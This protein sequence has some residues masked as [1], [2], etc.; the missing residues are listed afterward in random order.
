MTDLVDPAELAQRYVEETGRH[1]F[2]TGR[3]GT[4]K[5]T[6]L[7]KIYDSTGKRV[8]I[9]APTGVAAINAGGVTLHSLLQLPFGV[10]T[11]AAIAEKVPRIRFHAQKTA[12]L[13]SLDLLIIDEVSMVRADVLDGVDA[14]LR[15]VRQ[16]D[17]PF[18]GVQL[19]LIGDLYQLPPVVVRNEEQVLADHYPSPYF[20]DSRALKQANPRVITLTRVY[21]QS[22]GEFLDLLAAVR[23]NRLTDDDLH[24]LNQR[25]RPEPATPAASDDRITLSSHNRDADRINATRLAALPGEEFTFE[26][27]TTGKFP[28]SMY[29][30]EPTLS[31]RVGAR[32]M[33]NRNDPDK[34]YY[35][36]KIGRITAIDG[37]DIR[38]A[39]AEDEWP[40]TVTPATWENKQF[41][42]GDDDEVHERTVGT[43]VQ[44]PLRLAWAITIH[45]SQGL[46]FDRVIIDAGRAFAHGQVY[47]AL[48]RCRTLEGIELRTRIT[49]AAVR[50]DGTVNNFSH[51]AAANPPGPLQ[52]REDARAYAYRCLDQLLDPRQP[53]RR[54]EQLRR[55][56]ATH[57]RALPPVL[58]SATERLR[59]DLGKR[60]AEPARGFGAVVRR[61]AETLNL[62]SDH[63]ELAPRLPK[64][65]AY[66]TTLLTDDLLPR[67]RALAVDTDNAA[68]GARTAELIDEL[69]R[70]LFLR[71]EWFSALTAD[72]APP[73]FLRARS[74]AQR[75]WEELLRRRAATPAEAGPRREVTPQN[76]SNPV[77]YERLRRWRTREAASR[78][79]PQHQVL[80]LTVLHKIADRAPTTKAA[81]RAIPGVGKITVERYGK[82]LLALV[83]NAPRVVPAAGAGRRSTGPHKPE[84]QTLELFRT[85]K[86]PVDIAAARGVRSEA[87]MA[88]L[89]QLAEAGKLNPW[90]LVDDRAGLTT[91]VDHLRHHPGEKPS[92][93]HRHFGERYS[94]T[95]I[96]VARAVLRTGAKAE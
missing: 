69:H 45:K 38:V 85:G 23:D 82:D 27:T 32:V 88:Q 70:E 58:R 50:T 33:F 10:L 56:V 36:G 18:G 96:R 87:V 84:T 21:R 47:V 94:F 74:R 91:V 1:L 9:T 53:D 22:D 77:L 28:E 95:L 79:L 92:Q 71:R 59:M 49:P 76:V 26:A 61:A 81:L 57:E 8:V 16:T 44:H 24:R 40:I 29:P 68:V 35:N 17:Q 2:L 75:H 90:K 43:Y 13:R 80:Q 14:V 19:L 20:F 31:F 48:S 64:A 93:T 72:F 37:D 78:D 55:Y 11:P 30:N 41:S 54:A 83:R 86:S 25:F 67:V 15:R 39:C 7:R 66:F 51:A 42:S 34:E 4:G 62:P 63:P 73:A 46:T 3:A 12:L 60:Y 6:L 5:T 52:L 89:I 65:A